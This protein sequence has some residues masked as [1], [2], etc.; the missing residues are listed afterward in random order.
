VTVAQPLPAVQVCIRHQCR[1]CAQ[2]SSADNAVVKKRKGNLGR[3]GEHAA[4]DDLPRDLIEQLTLPDAGRW[5]DASATSGN[6][7]MPKIGHAFHTSS[8]HDNWG[9]SYSRGSSLVG[10]PSLAHVEL[11]HC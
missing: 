10:Y 6:L 9:G 8:R 5:P 2:I 11:W 1:E 7:A 3:R 4:C